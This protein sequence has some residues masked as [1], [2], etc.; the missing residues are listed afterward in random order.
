MNSLSLFVVIAAAVACGVAL[1]PH[2]GAIAA[3]FGGLTLLCIALVIAFAIA[4]GLFREGVSLFALLS[5]GVRIYFRTIPRAWSLLITPASPSEQGHLG[6]RF[7]GLV[8]LLVC[9]VLAI[10][11][12]GFALLL[13]FPTHAHT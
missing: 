8:V 3:I 2:V 13:L 6:R 9:V 1:A 10:V 4:K 12:I 7:D 11:I 5:A